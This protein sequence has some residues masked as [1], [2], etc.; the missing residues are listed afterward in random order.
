[1]PRW[2]ASETEST[3]AR[4]TRQT[5]HGRAVQGS[6]GSGHSPDRGRLRRPCEGL[7]LHARPMVSSGE[8]HT[9]SPLRPP[10]RHSSAE[11]PA[12]DLSRAHGQASRGPVP[13]C[14]PRGAAVHISWPAQLKPINP[15]SPH[16]ELSTR[17]SGRFANPPDIP[18]NSGDAPTFGP[19]AGGSTRHGKTPI[20]VDQARS[21]AL[22]PASPPSRLTAISAR[23]AATEWRPGCRH[24]ICTTDHQAADPRYG[25][26]RG[27]RRSSSARRTLL[28]ATTAG[29]PAGDR[30]RG[31]QA[32]A[33]P[34]VAFDR[35]PQR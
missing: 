28:V 19:S 3:I 13:S 26:G 22:R 18:L 29:D 30:H 24:L 35:S 15:R 6:L 25:S 12:R 21:G 1:V 4:Q 27:R 14:A 20:R 11:A 10:T 33:H 5:R 17:R 31:D 23:T 16:S 32:S 34:R 2:G 7:R 9:T 8:C